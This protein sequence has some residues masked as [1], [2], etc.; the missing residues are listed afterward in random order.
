VVKIYKKILFV[1]DGS[2][3]SDI[4][5]K[6]IIEFEREWDCKIV[7]FH[8]IKDNIHIS[9]FN[10]DNYNSSLNYRYNE[11]IRKEL[12][13]EIL[14]RTKKIFDEANLPVELQLIEDEDSESYIK[15]R[16]QQ[17]EFDLVVI[18]NDFHYK[19]KK[20]FLRPKFTKI[21]NHHT[22]DVLIMT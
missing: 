11:E 12:G 3:H 14:K 1:T 7:I 20:S 15:R 6:K 19:S 5:A 2:P 22:C 8:S 21:L 16:I 18:G 9:K 10:F 17:E 4:L 13:I